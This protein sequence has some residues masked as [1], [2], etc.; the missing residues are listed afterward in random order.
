MEPSNQ[1]G[2]TKDQHST[3]DVHT[4]RVKI[5]GAIKALEAFVPSR[6]LALVKTKLQEA[7]MWAGKELERMG[8]EL[9]AEYR[10]EATT[11]EPEPTPDNADVD[12]ADKA[13]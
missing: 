10:D 9:P 5:D 11:D 13:E 8:S 2:L 6:E 4:L 12:P 3:D 7:K 1:T